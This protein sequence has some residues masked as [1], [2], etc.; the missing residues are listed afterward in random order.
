MKARASRA[1]CI[2]HRNTVHSKLAA[3]GVLR[4]HGRMLIIDLSHIRPG[5]AIVLLALAFNLMGD[6]LRD[7]LDPVQRGRD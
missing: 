1:R 5:A 6:G 3:S 4:Q 7:V 2:S